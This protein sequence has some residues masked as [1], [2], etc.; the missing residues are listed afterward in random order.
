MTRL[1]DLTKTALLD[2]LKQFTKTFVIH[3]LRDLGFHDRRIVLRGWMYLKVG[4][5]FKVVS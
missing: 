5:F 1:L 3:P 4:G 2:L